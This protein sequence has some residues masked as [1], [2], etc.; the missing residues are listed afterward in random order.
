MS[1]ISM[2]VDTFRTNAGWKRSV[3][4]ANP[5]ERWKYWALRIGLTILLIVLS[6]IFTLHGTFELR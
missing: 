4:T 5:K 6:T 3:R 1:K 2:L